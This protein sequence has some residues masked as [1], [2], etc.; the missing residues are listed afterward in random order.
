MR[1]VVDHAHS[2]HPV[3]RS[4]IIHV[5]PPSSKVPP[6][7]CVCW[8]CRMAATRTATTMHLV[9][10]RELYVAEDPPRVDTNLIDRVHRD[11]R[12]TRRNPPVGEPPKEQ[13]DEIPIPAYGCPNRFECRDDPR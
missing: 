9:N 11:S 12:A 8:L 7:A 5:H 13:P 2:C 4:L 3:S 6:D 1:R 10:K